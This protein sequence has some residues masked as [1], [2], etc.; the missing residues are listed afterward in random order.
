MDNP[1]GVPVDEGPV[2]P[3]DEILEGAE[4][5]LEEIGVD[6]SQCVLITTTSAGRK[7]VPLTEPTAV[8]EV[9]RLAEFFASGP[10]TYWVNGVNVEPTEL[11][12]AGAEIM[13]VGVVKSG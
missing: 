6:P 12:A 10:V 9:M 3:L 4:Q 2:D 5:A 11:V 7:W 1:F 8:G 13:I